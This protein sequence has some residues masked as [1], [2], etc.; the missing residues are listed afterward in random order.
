MEVVHLGHW[1][2]LHALHRRL[3]AT[4]DAH[5]REQ[6]GLAHPAAEQHRDQ[7]VRAALARSPRHLQLQ[8]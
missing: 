7:A 6:M 1:H 8:Y 4:V 2:D 3:Q 5:D